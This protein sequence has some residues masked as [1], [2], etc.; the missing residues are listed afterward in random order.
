MRRISYLV[1]PIL[2]ALGSVAPV[3]PRAVGAEAVR[4][5]CSDAGAGGYEAFPDLC[6]T[7][8]GEL[9]CVFYAGYAHVSDPRPTLPRG[10]RIMLCRSRDDGRTWSQP[11]PVVDT[12]I[13]DRDSSILALPNGELLVT[14][15]TYDVR[16]RTGTHQVYTLRSQDNGKN[17]S[18]PEPLPTPFTQLEAISTPPR[19]MPDGRLLLTPYGNFTG[20]PRSYKH[21][22]VLESRDDGR[23]WKTLAE[24]RSPGKVLL[25][26]D[27]ISLPGNRLLLMARPEMLQAESADGGRTWTEP[28]PVG[29]EGDCPY[30]FRTS[31][32]ILLCG[33]RHRPTQS[34]AV[35][36]SRD[37]GRT[38]SE[39][40]VLDRVLGAYP[41]MV[42]LP[43]GK[44]LV[45]YY[46]EGPGSDV[47]CLRLEASQ[48]G[49]RT[50]AW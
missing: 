36:Y 40:V 33:I 13:D 47:R 43:D 3:H 32:G 29:V 44:I 10:A 37:D 38:W 21:A 28:K 8:G 16:R 31:K 9:L 11:E 23:S 7:P 42:E 5:V 30:L 2:A 24:V 46:T 39:P 20:D 41:S 17:W 35:I 26:P 4:T 34:T 1:I 50:I 14:F 12:P 19:R 27:L 48:A 49:V 25:E 22:A 45:V 15:M 18:E 6:R